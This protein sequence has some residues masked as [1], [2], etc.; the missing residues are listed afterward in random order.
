MAIIA[1]LRI[2][3]KNIHWDALVTLADRTPGSVANITELKVTFPGGGYVQL[4]GSD[5]PDSLRGLAWDSVFFDEAAYIAE[6]VF[7][8]IVRA[9]VSATQGRV[10]FVS[11]L[12]GRNWFYN[13]F[14]QAEAGEWGR[15]HVRCTDLQVLPASELASIRAT[16]NDEEWS[17][18]MECA[19]DAVQVGAIYAKLMT[20]AR[21]DGRIAHVPHAI[22]A[23]TSIRPGT[24]GG[25]TS[26]R[27]GSFNR[28]APRTM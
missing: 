4:F 20:Q 10:V 13:L 18:E 24:G 21:T 23:M 6:T 3:C 11:T 16:L 2:H 1:P 15:L 7:S 25:E 27:V 26:P 28:S 9:A 12:H 5:L 8:L 17:Q 19:W 14:Q 22:L